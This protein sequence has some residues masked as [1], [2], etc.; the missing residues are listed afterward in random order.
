MEAKD[1][2]SLPEAAPR[3]AAGGP[4]T[5]AVLPPGPVRRRGG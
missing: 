4:P 2:R 5:G 1:T 3:A